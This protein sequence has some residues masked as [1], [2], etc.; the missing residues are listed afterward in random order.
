[1]PQPHT[2]RLNLPN[3]SGQ[4]MSEYALLLGLIVIGVALLLP[5]I[6]TGLI[7]FFSGAAAAFGG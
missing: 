2:R 4:T 7:G 5:G 3:D 6:A 1:M